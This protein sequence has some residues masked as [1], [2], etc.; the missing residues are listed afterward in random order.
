MCEVGNRIARDSLQH[1][2]AHL[3]SFLRFLIMLG[4]IPAG[5]DNQIDT[6]CVYRE[7]KLPRALSWEVVQSLLKSVDCSTPM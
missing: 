1:A 3:R 5:I 6:P 4:E 2:V 7:E